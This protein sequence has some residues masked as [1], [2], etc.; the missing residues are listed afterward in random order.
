M[1]VYK[2]FTPLM[3]TT[4]YI[5]PKQTCMGKWIH[6]NINYHTL[7][8]LLMARWKMAAADTGCTYHRPLDLQGQCGGFANIIQAE[9]TA[10]Q[11]C[12][13]NALTTNKTG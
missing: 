3:R 2:R 13:L 4:I 9:L 12:C 1:I 8:T 10:I 5:N 7:Y 11:I 6:V